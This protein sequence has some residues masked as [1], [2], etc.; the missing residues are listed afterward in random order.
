MNNFNPPSEAAQS[1][2]LTTHASATASEPPPLGSTDSAAPLEQYSAIS[3]EAAPEA[4]E[5]APPPVF[6]P[7]VAVVVP[8]RPADCKRPLPNIPGLT[9][10][11][12]IALA[13]MIAGKAP[14]AA[15]RI[16]GVDRSTLYRWRTD[17][18]DFIAALNAWRDQALQSTMDHLRNAAQEAAVTVASAIRNGNIQVSLAIL[19]GVGALVPHP[20]GPRTPDAVQQTLDRDDIVESVQRLKERFNAII[21]QNYIGNRYEIQ[22]KDAWNSEKHRQMIDAYER[23]LAMQERMEPRETKEA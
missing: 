10:P 22:E 15:A 17:D 3:A 16:A 2:A 1:A 5:A 4:P 20:P 12:R 9:V 18:V 8:P 21:D 23:Q 14:N 11:Q 6:S 7:Q 19:K 13:A